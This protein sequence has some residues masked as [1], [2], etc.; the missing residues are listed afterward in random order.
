MAAILVNQIKD[1]KEYKKWQRKM[2]KKIE[3]L[4]EAY[5]KEHEVKDKNE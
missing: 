3:A 1:E 4:W 2:K 5:K